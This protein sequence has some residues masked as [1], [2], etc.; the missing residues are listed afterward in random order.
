MATY[1]VKS[2]GVEY[3]VTVVDKATG[4][5]LVTVDGREFDVKLSGDDTAPAVASR[6]AAPAWK[7]LAMASSPVASEA[8]PE[9]DGRIVAPIS[10]TIISLDVEVGDSVSVDQV[11]LRLEA[12]K[13]ENDITAPVAGTVQEITTN[14]GS[15]VSTGQLLMTIG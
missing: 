5:S 13:M 11:V 3:T 12:M 8:V 4:G 2:R 7:K 14:E 15:D 1:K 10:G 6:P 9:G